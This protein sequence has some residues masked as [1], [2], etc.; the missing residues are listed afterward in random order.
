MDVM[1]TGC[2][3]LGTLEPEGPGHDQ[4]AVANRLTACFSAM[5]FY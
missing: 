1:R 3:M 4:I 5:L 2:S